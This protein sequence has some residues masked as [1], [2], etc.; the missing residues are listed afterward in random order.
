[1]YRPFLALV[2]LA[3]IG[4][5][6]AAC[7]HK[8]TTV[9]SEGEVRDLGY[10]LFEVK[11]PKHQSLVVNIE[12]KDGKAGETY[13]LLA[14]DRAPLNVGWFDAK[15]RPRTC[16]E[17]D[18]HVRAQLRSECQLEGEGFLVDERSVT[19]SPVVLQHGADDAIQCDDGD[20]GCTYYY[21]VVASPAI[22]SLRTVHLTVE[23]GSDEGSVHDPS[24]RQLQ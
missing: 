6:M 21:A 12:V 23:S 2:A 19:P 10:A 1:M 18:L 13:L 5:G 22:S 8:S 7:G 4:I 15:N 3:A 24:I 14:S 9:E 20:H 16:T 11:V 17:G